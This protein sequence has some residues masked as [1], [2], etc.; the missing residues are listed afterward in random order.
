MLQV[1]KAKQGIVNVFD[2]LKYTFP[3]VTRIC[4]PMHLT[5]EAVEYEGEEAEYNRS[6]KVTGISE[7]TTGEVTLPYHAFD[8]NACE[9]P[10]E[11]AAE[12]FS[13]TQVKAFM[14][15]KPIAIDELI[16]TKEGDA[17]RVSATEGAFT[18]FG[19]RVFAL[20]E[21]PVDP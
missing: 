10:T 17:Y 1:N 4:N 15:T 2:L 8:L 11:I 9:C 12:M 18:V 6:L 14:K 5:V 3:N 7:H 13:L 16:F 20:A 19:E 21:E